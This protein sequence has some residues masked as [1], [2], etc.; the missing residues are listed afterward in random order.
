MARADG[1]KE[2]GIILSQLEQDNLKKT[3]FLQN[4]PVEPFKGTEDG[5]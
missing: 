1:E 2:G 5:I 3:M 4:M